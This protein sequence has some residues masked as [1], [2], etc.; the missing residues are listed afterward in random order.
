MFAYWRILSG[1]ASHKLC[2]SIFISNYHIYIFRAYFVHI[3]CIFRAYFVWLK[4]VC[5]CT[6]A[7]FFKWSPFVNLCVCTVYW[8]AGVSC[9]GVWLWVDGSV[10][11]K[12]VSLFYSCM[13][14]IGA[15]YSQCWL[16]TY[17]FCAQTDNLRT[18]LGVILTRIWY[19]HG[20]FTNTEV[21][22]LHHTN[23][24]THTHG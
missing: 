7:G 23:Y 4:L 9:A 20:K 11:T 12:G 13:Y 1:R 14:P 6:K 16:Y 3:S 17:W 8:I 24:D 21:Y 18:M 10:F 2:W 22:K 19:L 15:G 5:V